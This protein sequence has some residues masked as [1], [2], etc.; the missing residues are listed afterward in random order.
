MSVGPIG[1]SVPYALAC[2]PKPTPPADGPAQNTGPAAPPSEEQA[3]S[4]EQAADRIPSAK[5]SE[6]LQ[7]QQEKQKERGPG[8]ADYVELTLKEKQIV[9]SLRQRDREV[10]AHEQAHKAVGGRFVRGAPSY[11]YRT[12][13][14]QRE[15]AVGGEV[16]IDAAPVPGDPQATMVKARTVKR[17]A[18]APAQ[19]SATDR[20]VAAQAARSEAEARAELARQQTQ[21]AELAARQKEAEQLG[22]PPRDP[23]T[24]SGFGQSR[25]PP[26]TE[27]P[28]TTINRYV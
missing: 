27:R 23:Y 25:P 8:P 18:L 19:P 15:Y 11:E 2:G 26:D 7:S 16:A 9:Q 10:R 12:G 28:S 14:D 24:E 13:P 21:Q 6:Q 3:G 20:Q 5:D 17:A 22:Q 4:A 1:T